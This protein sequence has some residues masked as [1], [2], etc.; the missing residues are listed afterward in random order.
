MKKYAKAWAA[1]LMLFLGSLSQATDGTALWPIRGLLSSI[2]FA[3]LVAALGVAL[4]GT[5]VVARIPN[6]EKKA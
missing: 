4:I 2:T 3:E 5:G 6:G 1:G